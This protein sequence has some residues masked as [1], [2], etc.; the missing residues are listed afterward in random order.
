MKYEGQTPIFS[1]A[2]IPG[3]EYGSLTL[4]FQAWE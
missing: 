4:I 2:T 3:R 1:F